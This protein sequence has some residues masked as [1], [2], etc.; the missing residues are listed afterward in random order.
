MKSV[1]EEI[2]MDNEGIS[3]KIKE[4][5]RF[6]EIED[7]INEIV[8][9]L[10]KSFNDEQKNAYRKLDFLYAEQEGEMTYNHFKEG[11]KL[12]FRL[13]LELLYR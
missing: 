10:D 11:F 6:W 12:G 7:E 3:E 5:K 1:I 9:E 2:Y 13:C 4:T 8:S